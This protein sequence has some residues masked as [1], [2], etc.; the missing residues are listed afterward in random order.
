VTSTYTGQRRV[1][2][3][4]LAALLPSRGLVSR[5][6]GSGEPVLWIWHPGTGRQTIVFATPTADAW[7]FLW[8]PG[9]Q[10]GTDDPGATAEAIRATLT[11][12]PA[13]PA[14]HLRPASPG[15]D[16]HD[17][18]HGEHAETERSRPERSRPERPGP[19]RSGT[20][21]PKPERPEERRPPYPEEGT[22]P[23]PPYNGA[24]IPD[25][26]EGNGPGGTGRHDEPGRY[27]EADKAHWYRRTPRVPKRR[28]EQDPPA[29][30]PGDEAAPRPV[31]RADHG[32]R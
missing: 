32:H 11:G 31:Q 12:D 28:D 19:E 4:A 13:P 23:R 15:G 14:A 29:G 2:L 1:H 26:H 7:V 22:P 5:I 27:G 9:G 21:R 6:V 20:K 18:R 8:S 24:P 25:R 10:S 17:E 3:E 16:R 30:E